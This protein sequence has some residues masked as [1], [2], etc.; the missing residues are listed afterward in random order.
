MEG[1]E[2]AYVTGNRHLN[3]RICSNINK[4]TIYFKC[5]MSCNAIVALNCDFLESSGWWLVIADSKALGGGG[6]CI[7]ES[8]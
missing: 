1:A 2:N 4:L 7:D 3:G 6:V 5:V 8:H